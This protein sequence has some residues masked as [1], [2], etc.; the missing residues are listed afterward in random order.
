MLVLTGPITCVIAATIGVDHA[1]L[2]RHR[3]RRKTCCRNWLAWWSGDTLGVL[4][5]MPLVLLAPG[6]QDAM[7]LARAAG[8]AACRFGALLLLLLPLALTFYAWKGTTENDYQRGEA[9]F[10]T[11]TI[12]S[13]KALQN[14]LD[15]YGNALLGAAGFIQGSTAVS[16]DEWRTYVETVRVRENFPGINGLG[17]IQPVAN[18]DNWNVSW[19]RRAPMAR[20][21]SRSTRRQRRSLT[22]SSPSSSLRQATRARSA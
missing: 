6:S 1:L 7:R 18:D 11:L 14:R 4:V 2:P 12:E 20:R 22:T 16:R 17:W 8:R 10:R 15:S 3:R 5:F 19:P 21:T 13:E 9:K